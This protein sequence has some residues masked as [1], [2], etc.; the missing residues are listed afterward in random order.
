MNLKEIVKKSG[1]LH[2]E[3]AEKMFPGVTYAYQSYD[4]YSK[5]N[6]PLNENHLKALSEVTGYSIAE[7]MEMKDG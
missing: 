5:L 4:R 2:R 6:I 7:I 3:A 1:K